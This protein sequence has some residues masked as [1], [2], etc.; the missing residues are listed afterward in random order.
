MADNMVP[1][2]PQMFPSMSQAPPIVSTEPSFLHHRVPNPMVTSTRGMPPPPPPPQMWMPNMT[3]CWYKCLGYLFMGYFM[4]KL[5]FIYIDVI[6]VP[7]LYSLMYS[8]I[9]YKAA[10]R[11]F[12]EPRESRII[13]EWHYFAILSYTYHSKYRFP[14]KITQRKFQFHCHSMS[15]VQFVLIKLV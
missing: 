11:L 10:R 9:I 12:P 13:N 7:Q 14:Y 4:Y 1:V 2:D 15:F 5:Y 3:Q 8:T 6:L